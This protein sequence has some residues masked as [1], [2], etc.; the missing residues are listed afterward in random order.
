MIF[1]TTG[2]NGTAKTLI[3]LKVI[4]DRQVAEGRK[5][6]YNGFD[7][8]PAK[9]AEFGWEKFDPVEWEKCDD[10]A[11][12]FCDECQNQFPKR[13]GSQAE[14]KFVTAIGE[15][16]KRGFDFY[17]ITQ[18]PTRLDA[19]VRKIIAAPGY[20]RHHKRTAGIDMVSVLQWDAVNDQCEK[21]GSGKNARVT[22]TPFPKEVY[23]WYTSAVLHTAKRTIPRQVYVL[24]ACVLIVP[25]LGYFVY[26]RLYTM[27]SPRD[28]AA[29]GGDSGQLVAGPSVPRPQ[30]VS[31][32]GSFVP[33]V[34]G[35]PHTAPRYDGVTEATV[36]PYPAACVA[37][38][39]LC[40]CFTQQGTRLQVPADLCK[41]IVAG[42][43]FMDWEPPARAEQPPVASDPPMLAAPVAAPSPAS[44]DAT[45]DGRVLAGMRGASIAR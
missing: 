34:P 31:Y 15:H 24:A 13:S 20:H 10:G 12:L 4:R 16:R 26:E 39:S 45:R 22:M 44:P 14:P 38:V 1:L 35:L 7:M 37:S 9:A 25:V 40:R 30:P 43:F 36:A 19:A 21:F 18:H 6:Y 28:L 5:V 42:G 41:Q 17:L 23:K 3:T 29:A 2:G 33:R 8:D 11:I 27:A 32:L